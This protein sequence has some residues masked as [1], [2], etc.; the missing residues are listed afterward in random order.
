LLVLSGATLVTMTDNEQRPGGDVGDDRAADDPG[1]LLAS[2]E[3]RTQRPL[4][5]LALATVWIVVVPPGDF[6]AG[7]GVG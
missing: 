6:G 1:G 5:L 7:H 3:A 2:Y 4:D